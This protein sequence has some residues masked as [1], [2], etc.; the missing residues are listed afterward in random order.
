MVEKR[1]FIPQTKRRPCAPL[2]EAVKSSRE[3]MCGN[4]YV[5]VAPPKSVIRQMA[6]AVEFAVRMKIR[7]EESQHVGYDDDKPYVDVDGRDED[8]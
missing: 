7:V 3:N 6:A 1:C 5:G 8:K 4:T 2:R